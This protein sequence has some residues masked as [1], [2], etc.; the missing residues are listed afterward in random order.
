MTVDRWFRDIGAPESLRKLTLDQLVIG[1]L[2][3]K[4]DRV[5]AF[6]FARALHFIGRGNSSAGRSNRCTS[7]IRKRAP[8]GFCE[9]R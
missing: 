3:E 8:R 7:T 5:S 1:L 4:P 9:P 2:N 6:T